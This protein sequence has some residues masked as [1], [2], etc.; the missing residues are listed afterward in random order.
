MKI[1]ITQPLLK[2]VVMQEARK[3]HE[4]YL[5]LQKVMRDAINPQEVPEDVPIKLRVEEDGSLIV[6]VEE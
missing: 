4:S 3:H 5:H 6:E 2:Q 1:E